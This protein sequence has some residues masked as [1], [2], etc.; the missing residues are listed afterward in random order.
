MG[1]ALNHMHF[2]SEILKTHA[3]RALKH[4]HLKHGF[5]SRYSRRGLNHMHFDIGILNNAAGALEN[6]NC[7]KDSVQVMVAEP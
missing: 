1:R 6:I 5:L 2:Y 3:T 7:Y 4:M